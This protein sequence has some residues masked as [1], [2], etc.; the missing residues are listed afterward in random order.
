MEKKNHDW[1]TISREYI[2]GYRQDD[3]SIRYPTTEELA[4]KY[5]IRGNRVRD[6]CAE[7]RWRDKREAFKRKV[8]NLV[9][10]NRARSRAK[11]IETFTGDCLKVSKGGLWPLMKSLEHI[12]RR[13]EK[14]GDIS[15][16]DLTKLEQISRT[17]ERLQKS[18]H[19]ALGIPQ[20]MLQIKSEEISTLEISTGNL[21]PEE[22]KRKLELIQ[23]RAKAL[24]D[25]LTG[26][27]LQRP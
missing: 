8:A 23:L 19:L 4:E 5:K 20:S 18:G 6:H 9:E 27:S 14:S 15:K 12:I 25:D 16:E 1:L 10:H 7:E 3:G 2:E 24:Q 21:T 26:G 13:T 17:L 22:R 11:E